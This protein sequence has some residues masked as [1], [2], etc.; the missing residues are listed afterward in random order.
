MANS[1][2]APESFNSGSMERRAATPADWGEMVRTMHGVMV[3]FCIFIYL[4]FEKTDFG[5]ATGAP[6]PAAIVPVLAC[7]WSSWAA[8]FLA[9]LAWKGS[10]TGKVMDCLS[11]ASGLALLGFL[12]YYV[13]GGYAVIMLGVSCLILAVALY[14]S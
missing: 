14:Y 13:I 6:I 8:F 11:I 12:F 4:I 9:A 2:I 1:K 10:G 3:A 5:A 7:A